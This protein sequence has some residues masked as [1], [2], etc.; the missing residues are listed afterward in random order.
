MS[1]WHR[2]R[3]ILGL[4]VIRFEQPV[5]DELQNLAEQERRPKEAVAADLIALGLVRRRAAEASL[6]R[7]RQL[8]PREQQVAALVCRGY[9]NRQIAARLKISLPTV[10]THVRNILIKF[11]L[12]RRVD[13][14][15]SLAD[16]DFSGWE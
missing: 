2:L 13:L 8:S 3:R 1:L 4:Q 12:S 15:Q 9:T 11:G 5:I 6:H 10:K 7:W 14:Q 16:W